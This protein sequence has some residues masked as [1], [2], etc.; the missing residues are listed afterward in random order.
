MGLVD[1]CRIS[2]TND[3]KAHETH[4]HRMW[5]IPPQSAEEVG[6]IHVQPRS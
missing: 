6:R 4:I 5:K 3:K 2:R 1:K